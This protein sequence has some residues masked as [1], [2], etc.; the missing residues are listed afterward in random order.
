MADFCKRSNNNNKK[1]GPPSFHADTACRQPLALLPAPWLRLPQ[2]PLAS[3]A[4]AGALVQL[5]PAN[6]LSTAADARLPLPL[7]LPLGCRDAQLR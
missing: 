1:F 2:S 5:Q 7:L 3:P 4:L 6:W